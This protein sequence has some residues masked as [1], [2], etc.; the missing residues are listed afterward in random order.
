MMRNVLENMD[1]NEEKWGGV[2]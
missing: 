1:I 2:S